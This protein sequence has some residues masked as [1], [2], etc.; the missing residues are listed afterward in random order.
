MLYQPGKKHRVVFQVDLFP[1][2][3]ALPATLNEVSE[4]EKDIRFSS[5]TRLNTTN[6]LDR[7]VIAQAAKRLIDKLPLELRDDPDALALAS[8]RC[9][10]AVDVVH[11]IYRDKHY[12]SQS[13]DYEFSRLSMQ[14]HWTSGHTDM[15][16]TLRDPR[17]V[18]HDSSVSGVRVFDLTSDC[19]DGAK[20]ATRKDAARPQLNATLRP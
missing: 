14:E 13:K 8:M 19:F 4:R 7:Q 5:R 6:E 1:A 16:H 11:L 12:E 17:W 10:T 2:V 18:N 9:E 3:G 15:T 20:P